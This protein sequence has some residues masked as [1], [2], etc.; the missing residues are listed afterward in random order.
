[1]LNPVYYLKRVRYADPMEEQMPEQLRKVL[2]RNT[3][4][5]NISM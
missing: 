1:M 2:S 5:D 4:E 3:V